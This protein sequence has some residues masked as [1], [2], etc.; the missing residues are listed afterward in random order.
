VGALSGE[1]VRGDHRSGQVDTGVSE[2][3]E[4]RGEHGDLVGL[5][6]NLDLAQHQG[7]AMG[8]GREQMHLVALGVGGAA[9]GL[10]I[11]RD[12]DQPAWLAGGLAGGAL[13]CGSLPASQAP[14]TAST[15]AASAPV[16]TRQIVAFDGAWVARPY[17]WTSNSAGTS[18]AQPATAVKEPMPATTAAAHKA[19]T[20]ATGWT[21]P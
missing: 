5:C 19:S 13:T 2:T 12:R 18:T 17:S 6:T 14:M 9:H 21:R 20:T 11:H 7:V 8:R 15:A 4:Q 16:T 1:G 3:I 10:T